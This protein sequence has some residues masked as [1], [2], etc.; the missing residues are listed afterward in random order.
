M[1]HCHCRV[2][3]QVGQVPGEHG[4][5]LSRSKATAS[6]WTEV[7]RREGP[8][9]GQMTQFVL[10]R[11][12]ILAWVGKAISLNSKKV[13]LISDN[14]LAQ[15]LGEIGDVGLLGSCLGEL[16][17]GEEVELGLSMRAQLIL[18]IL[19]CLFRVDGNDRNALGILINLLHYT[20]FLDDVA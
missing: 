12:I 16:G 14:L 13:F 11:K 20:R 6:E 15:Y 2:P 19:L 18:D 10:Q 3:L 1:P 9:S 7:L 5:A 17:L 8:K 4:G